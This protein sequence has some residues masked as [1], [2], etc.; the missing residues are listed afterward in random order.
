MSEAARHRLGMGLAGLALATA[1]FSVAAVPVAALGRLLGWWPTLPWMVASFRWA[2]TA[3]PAA[4]LLALIALVWNRRAGWRSLRRAASL[5]ALLLVVAAGI[6]MAP[7]AWRA[8]HVPP[9][10]DITTDTADPPRLVALAAERAAK[11][12]RNETQYDPALTPLQRASNPD[13]GPKELALPASDAFARALAAARE[14]GW[15]IAVADP[16]SG[17]I[18]AVATT[19]WAGFEDDVVIRVTAEGAAMSRVDM[20]SVSR[21]GRSDIGTNAARIR[22]FLTKLG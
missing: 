4:L 12:L 7:L 16:A 17:R 11:K 18:E 5:G 3:A 13:I 9:I 10:H 20:R 15:R 8:L 2:I 22:A 21:V 14:M 19:F 1:L 6:A